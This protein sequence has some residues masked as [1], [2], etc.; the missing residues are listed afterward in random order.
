MSVFFYK[1]FTS[2]I[3]CHQ[4]TFT[5]GV[6]CM[7]GML[8]TVKNGHQPSSEEESRWQGRAGLEA[9]TQGDRPRK[10]EEKEESKVMAT[11]MRVIFV[12]QCP[13]DLFNSR[14]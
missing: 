1:I 7:R 6:L 11:G 4:H 5:E 9:G 14:R 2:Y 13:F 12:V 8:V 10:Q 3:L